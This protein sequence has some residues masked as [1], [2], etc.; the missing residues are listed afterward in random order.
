MGRE[1]LAHTLFTQEMLK[2][3]TWYEADK[4]QELLDKLIEENGLKEAQKIMAD[5][6]FEDLQAQADKQT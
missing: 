1:E 5:T 2:Y 6:N 3:T 4:R